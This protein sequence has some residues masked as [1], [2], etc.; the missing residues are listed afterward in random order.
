MIQSET[1]DSDVISA[2]ASQERW[3]KGNE[4]QFCK[5]DIRLVTKI[6]RNDKIA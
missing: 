2:G 6:E 4:S 1:D 5:Y 3:E